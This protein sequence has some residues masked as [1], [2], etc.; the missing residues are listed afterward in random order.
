MRYSS[1]TCPYRNDGLTLIEMIVALA[2]LTILIALG[3]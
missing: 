2:V 1:L 3:V